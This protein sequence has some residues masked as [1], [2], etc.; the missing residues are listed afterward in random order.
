MATH[1]IGIDIGSYESKGN[2]TDENGKVLASHV[3]RHQLDFVKPGFVEHDV[4][5]IWW[6]TTT[7]AARFSN[8]P[9]WT[10]RASRALA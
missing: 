10:L 3:T 6:G 9:P 1:L 2:L 7:S 5:T 8:N 4:E